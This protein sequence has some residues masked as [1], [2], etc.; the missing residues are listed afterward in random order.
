MLANRL[1]I[2]QPTQV[3]YHYNNAGI[4]GGSKEDLDEM[5]KFNAAPNNHR[6]YPGTIRVIDQNGDNRINADD[7][8]VRGSNRPK[9]TGGI[10]N[11]FRYKNWSLSS[12][13]YARVGQKYFGGY[14]NAFGGTNPNGRVVDNVWSWKTQSGRWPIPIIGPTVDNFAPA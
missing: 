9:W 7:Y 10:T 14:P 2:G 1:F 11:I 13:I 12:F 5:A 6:F 3:F 4:W 8:V